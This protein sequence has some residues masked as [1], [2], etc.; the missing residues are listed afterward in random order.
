MVAR[1]ESAG[2]VWMAG[3]CDERQSMKTTGSGDGAHRINAP[4][5]TLIDLLVV[6]A[7]IA[8]LAGMLLPAL[9]KA[10]ETGRRLACA[11]NMRQLGLAALMFPDDNQGNFPM[12]ELGA[13]P[14]AWPPVPA[15][16]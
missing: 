10:R 15:T 14:G 16:G 13:D 5:F 9:G 8:I 11:D 7:I 4:G 6:I 1:R 3:W 2:A 12:C